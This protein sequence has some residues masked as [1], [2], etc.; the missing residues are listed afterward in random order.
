[1]AEDKTQVE[2]TRSENKQPP[3]LSQSREVARTSEKASQG[4]SP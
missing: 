1:V 3:T 4:G 2:A